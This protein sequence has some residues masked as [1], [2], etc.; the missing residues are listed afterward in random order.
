MSHADQL[1]PHLAS[2]NSRKNLYGGE[3]R[4]EANVVHLQYGK[5]ALIWGEQRLFMISF[6][7]KHTHE[8]VNA[9]LPRMRLCVFICAA[10]NLSE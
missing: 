4:R 5:Y 10:V 7:A 1:A 6:S 9:A 3:L 2:Q 8:R